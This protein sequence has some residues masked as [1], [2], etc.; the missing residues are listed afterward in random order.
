M[1]RHVQDGVHR[2]LWSADVTAGHPW[3]YMCYT[4][5]G[6][7]RL[8]GEHLILA[9]TFVYFYLSPPTGS[10]LRALKTILKSGEVHAVNKAK[11]SQGSFRLQ[12]RKVFRYARTYLLEKAYYI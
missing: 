7:D 12:R 11:F 10:L 3:L 4:T 9:P 5:P 6:F 8:V 2:Q 1:L